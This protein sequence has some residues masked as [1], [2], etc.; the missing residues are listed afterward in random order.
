MN[1]KLYRLITSKN[2]FKIINTYHRIFGE[3]FKKKIPIPSMFSFKI[4][5]LNVINNLIQKLKISSY[6]EIG[7]DQDEVFSF[8]KIEN[9]IGVDPVSGG[10]HRMTS[11]T[12]FRDNSK[13]FD[14]IFID[15]LHT[16]DQVKKDIINSNVIILTKPNRH[17]QL[18]NKKNIYFYSTKGI[19]NSKNNLLK[20]MESVEIKSSDEI[21]LTT[22]NIVYNIKTNIINGED[23]VKLDG[24]W[25]ILKGV[26]FSYNLEKSI[27]NIK[28]RPKL[29]LYNNKGKI[30]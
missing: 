17:Y 26:G 24:K 16:Y 20:L 9:K 18:S 11:D 10:T 27:I 7:C 25:G 5:R 3:K 12:F 28:G 2:Y 13:F 1:K 4:H 8:V 30:K 22:S 19:L 21:H 29:T 14:L 15:G 6:L 23:I